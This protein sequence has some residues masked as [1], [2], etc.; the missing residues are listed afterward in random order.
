MV[1]AC[2]SNLGVLLVSLPV[3]V[4]L[5]CAGKFVFF[6]LAIAGA[7]DIMIIS[8]FAFLAVR[9]LGYA[10]APA[11]WCGIGMTTAFVWGAAVFQ[12]PTSDIVAAAFAIGLLI[13]GVALIS[14]SQAAPS[15]MSVKAVTPPA[16]SWAYLFCL[17]TGLFDG[18]LMVP[19]KFSHTRSLSDV[20]SYLASFGI[21]TAI[22]TPTLFML[23]YLIVLRGQFPNM[24]LST[25]LRPGIASGVLWGSANFLSVH[26]TNYLVRYYV[27]VEFIPFKYLL[28]HQNRLSSNPNMHS[29]NSI[30]GDNIFQGDRDVDLGF[31]NEIWIRG[32]FYFVRCS[33]ARTFW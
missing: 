11:I 14:L 31:Q 10:T 13:A 26:A 12:E 27:S 30:V 5:L 6:P 33:A 16:S 19:F 24:Y 20:L 1:F 8:Y 23:Y 18:S 22:A 17:L 7:A 9:E 3:L 15:E 28:G 32:G 4:Y 29:D 21:G 25:A 2:Y